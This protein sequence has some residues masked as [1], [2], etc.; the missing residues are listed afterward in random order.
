MSLPFPGLIF[1]FLAK[2]NGQQRTLE[3]RHPSAQRGLGLLLA[4]SSN[5]LAAPSL[6]HLGK[7]SLLGAFGDLESVYRA[8]EKV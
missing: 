2:N 4:E 7:N 8:A 6:G 3:G 1:S 5:C